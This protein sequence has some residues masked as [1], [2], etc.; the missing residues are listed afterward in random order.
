VPVLYSG[1]AI[2]E[3]SAQAE[4]DELLAAGLQRFTVR[5]LGPTAIQVDH[6]RLVEVR[7]LFERLGQTPRIVRG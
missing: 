7:K 5:R 4:L 3:T 2:V 6:E 1:M